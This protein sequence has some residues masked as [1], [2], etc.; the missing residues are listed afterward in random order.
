MS[1]AHKLFRPS[2]HKI[3]N[4][5]D[6]LGGHVKRAIML[7][8]PIKVLSSNCESKHFVLV[9]EIWNLFEIWCLCFEFFT[10]EAQN[11]I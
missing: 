4:V 9:I 6:Q 10:L 5:F 11:D 8:W 1:G 7:D 3:D 2:L